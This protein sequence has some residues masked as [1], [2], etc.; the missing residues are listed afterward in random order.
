M[1][2]STASPE[3]PLTIE[4]GR[5]DAMRRIAVRAR[6]GD[7]P[8]LFWLGGFKSDMRGTKALA[9]AG[10]KRRGIRAVL[11]WPAGGDRL[12]HGRVDGAAVGAGTRQASCPPRLAEGACADCAGAR[13]HRGTNV[14]GV[15][16]RHSTPD[17][18]HG[19]VA[20][21]GRIRRPLSAH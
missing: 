13:F 12:L 8:G 20:A 17:R 9:L 14:E 6:E 21:A 15:F 19:R 2:G 18:D 10:R 1:T 7:L 4:V 11:R 5:T 3:K 16:V